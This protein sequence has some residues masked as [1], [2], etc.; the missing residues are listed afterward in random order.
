[1]YG[2]K[3]KHF[4]RERANLCTETLMFVEYFADDLKS[5]AN[6]ASSLYMSAKRRQVIHDAGYD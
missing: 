6:L 4:S 3:T 1:L 5:F 2:A